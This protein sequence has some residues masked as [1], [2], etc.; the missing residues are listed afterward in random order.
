M[1]RGLIVDD[2]TIMRVR[3]R[4]I[5]EPRYT[6]VAEA[7]NGTEAIEQFLLHKP[8]FITLDISMPEKNGIEAL[9]TLVHT[10]GA[11]RIII[12]SAV[13]QQKLVLQTLEMG[14]ADFVVKPFETARVLMAVDRVLAKN[15]IG[16]A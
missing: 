8:D 9:H 10:H 16:D 12:V 7:A 4:E 11:S 3:L 14:A 6:I 15:P 5:L 1:A 13:G 2:A